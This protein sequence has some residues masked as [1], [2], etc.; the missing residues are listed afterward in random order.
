MFLLSALVACS[1]NAP[2]P[3]PPHGWGTGWTGWVLMPYGAVIDGDLEGIGF[4]DEIC[5]AVW[6][7]LCN[8]ITAAGVRRPVV[9]SAR[10]LRLYRFRLFRISGDRPR[11]SHTC[12]PLGRRKGAA[13]GALPQNGR[14]KGGQDLPR[15]DAGLFGGDDFAFVLLCVRGTPNFT[16]LA[17]RPLSRGGSIR[18]RQGRGE[19]R[20]H[21]FFL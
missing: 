17:L 8:L 18:Q 21:R 6:G 5:V 20:P 1:T 3:L 13:G 12:L 7:P 19:V 15:P 9:V 16:L 14:G 11:Q 10:R 2:T 4:R